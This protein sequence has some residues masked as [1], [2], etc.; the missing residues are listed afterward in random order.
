V[1]AQQVCVRV[2]NTTSPTVGSTTNLLFAIP[3]P[4]STAGAG[5]NYT[6]PWPGVNSTG[7]IGFVLVDSFITTSTAI[8]HSAGE[9]VGQLYY[10]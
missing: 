1:S 4:G 8:G 3:I 10:I 5:N 7:G 9:V 6:L 2:Y